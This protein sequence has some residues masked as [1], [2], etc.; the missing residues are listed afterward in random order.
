MM[1][2]VPIR[3]VPYDPDWAV[4]FEQ[5]CALLEQVLAPW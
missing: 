5:E 2:G 4:R 1:E 3:V